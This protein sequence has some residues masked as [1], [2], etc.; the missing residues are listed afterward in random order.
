[1]GGATGFERR[2]RRRRRGGRKR[3]RRRQK[4]VG[5]KKS[6]VVTSGTR[7]GTSAHVVRTHDT[8]LFFQKRK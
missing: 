5:K 1:M 6:H 7:S 8:P 3:R 4:I 2:R